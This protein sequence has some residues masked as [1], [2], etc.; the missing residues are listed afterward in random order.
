MSSENY[1][2]ISRLLCIGLALFDLVLAGQVLILPQLFL[3]MMQPSLIGHPFELLY[4]IGALWA[5]FMVVEFFAFFV[6]NKKPELF[7]IVGCLR[8]MD[9][10]ADPVWLITGKGFT[11]FGIFGLIFAACFNLISGIILVKAYYNLRSSLA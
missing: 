7:L 9:V 1:L 2:K 3:E 11:A 10:T 8:L 6:G 5:F 4:R